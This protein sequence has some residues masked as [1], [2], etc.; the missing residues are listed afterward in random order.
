MEGFIEE[1]IFVLSFKERMEL[2]EWI[3]GRII[4]RGIK[5]V[6]WVWKW[7]YIRIF[8]VVIDRM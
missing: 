3:K 4:L 2:V 1:V 6:K 5:R 8:L 7:L